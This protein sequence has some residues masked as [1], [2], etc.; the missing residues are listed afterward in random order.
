M[1][2]IRFLCILPS[3]FFVLNI[4]I[5][6]FNL[7]QTQSNGPT[8]ERCP[9]G[10]ILYTNQ[11]C[12][13]KGNSMKRCPDGYIRYT[14]ELCYPKGKKS[15]EKE[16]QF[17]QSAI[18]ATLI[19]TALR[20]P[21][22]QKNNSCPYGSI[23]IK[24]KCR[25]ILCSLGEYYKG[26]CLHPVCPSGL[27]WRGKKCQEP[28]YITTVIEIQNDFV[29][30]VNENPI[31]LSKSHKNNV[32]YR[33]ST[34]T[35]HKP[36]TTSAMQQKNT[37]IPT[38]VSTSTTTNSPINSQHIDCCKVLT[39][40]ICKLYGEKWVCFNRKYQRCDSRICASPVVYLKAPAIK[41]EP[42]VLIMPPNPQLTDCEANDCRNN[43]NVDCSGCATLRSENC[44]PYCY[45]YICPTD[46]CSFMDLNEYCSYY[47]GQ[48]GCLPTDGCLWNWC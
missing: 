36:F 37:T 16:T 13:P 26:S 10:Y 48:S 45:Q 34:T 40:R 15:D 20:S 30:H 44:S 24:N 23:M 12:Y 2:G 21:V 9:E 18:V 43:L 11:L 41:H 17:Q 39:P 46:T 6:K 31:A 14:N 42:P 32:V 22:G 5:A 7:I 38:Y 29:S 28:G 25:K 35:T 4:L 1:G 3:Y 47:S 33:S 19:T 8:T 27:V